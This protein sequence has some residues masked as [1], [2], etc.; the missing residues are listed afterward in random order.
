[1]F[2]TSGSWKFCNTSDLTRR[3]FPVGLFRRGHIPRE[4]R[5]RLHPNSNLATLAEA[6]SGRY[7]VATG[8][9]HCS[10]LTVYLWEPYNIQNALLR[11][12]CR[13]GRTKL[14]YT[15]CTK[16][17]KNFSNFVYSQTLRCDVRIAL[18]V[19][20]LCLEENVYLS[21]RC[22]KKDTFL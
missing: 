17:I 15:F 21:S 20:K 10:R 7:F 8:R 5:S 11:R 1:M 9:L 12:S 2:P 13:V 22:R 3:T 19:R 4:L 14:R 16:K 18:T 6:I